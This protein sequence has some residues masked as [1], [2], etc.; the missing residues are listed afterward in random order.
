M[1]ICCLPEKTYTVTVLVTIRHLWG[2][3]TN[4]F[5]LEDLQ[6]MAP[7][8]ESDHDWGQCLPSEITPVQPVTTITRVYISSTK[9]NFSIIVKH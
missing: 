3:Y 1:Y 9:Y 8:S 5:L 6:L 2:E 7:T 4:V